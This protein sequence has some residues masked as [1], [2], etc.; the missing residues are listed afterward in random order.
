MMI[1]FHDRKIKKMSLDSSLTKKVLTATNVIFT[2]LIF[3]FVVSELYGVNEDLKCK[4]G[5]TMTDEKKIDG[6]ED[7]GSQTAPKIDDGTQLGTENESGEGE[8]GIGSIGRGGVNTNEPRKAAGPTEEVKTLD[9]LQY[10]FSGSP[11]GYFRLGTFLF[12]WGSGGAFFSKNFDQIFGLIATKHTTDTRGKKNP[13]V[14]IMER[15]SAEIHNGGHCL[16][17]AWGYKATED[18]GFF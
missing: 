8:G 2:V 7:V 5:N 18:R 11:N 10:E 9:P 12:Q 14:K 1:L 13:K 17:C 4:S 15:N 3:S 16:W 6:F